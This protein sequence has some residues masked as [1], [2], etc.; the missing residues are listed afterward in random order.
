MGSIVSVIIPTH[1]RLDMLE[2][3][4]ESVLMQT[5]MPDEVIVI[6]DHI[7][8]DIQVRDLVANYSNVRYLKNFETPGANQSRNLGISESVGDYVAFLD[9]DDFWCD[10]YLFEQLKTIEVHKV[11]LVYSD[12]V[13]FWDGLDRKITILVQTNEAP[14]D[15]NNK[16]SQGLFCPET[17]SAVVVKTSAIKEVGCFDIELES[18]QDWDLWYRLSKK[19]KF[20]RTKGCLVNFRQH[21]GIR[22]SVTYSKRLKGLNQVLEKWNGELGTEFESIYTSGCYYSNAKRK[23]MFGDWRGSFAGLGKVCFFRSAIG[24]KMFFEIIYKN[25]KYNLIRI[26]IT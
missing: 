25:V 19:I 22:T 3:A 16:M 26:R 15:L 18:F 10:E 24:M 23:M 20:K 7:D 2:E 6:N 4:I 11:D 9:D 13:E 12:Y 14:D 21:D 8:T 1:N 17:T 5:R